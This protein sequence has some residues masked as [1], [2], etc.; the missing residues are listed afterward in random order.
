MEKALKILSA[1]TTF[2]VAVG[3]ILKQ[4]N[5]YTAS[6]TNDGGKSQTPPAA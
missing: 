3:E 1:V 6:K 4:V 5:Q 2:L